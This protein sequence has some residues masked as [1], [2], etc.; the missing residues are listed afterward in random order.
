MAMRMLRRE[1]SP[2]AV[3]SA[4][5]K[6]E[7]LSR[8]QAY[9]YLLQGQSQRQLEPLPQAKAVF[10]VNLPRRLIQEVRSRC[11]GQGR[12]ISHVVAEV[13]QKW[14]DQQRTHG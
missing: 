12:P 14:L 2:G 11:R 6:A 1:Q 4:L 13:L 10:T 3:L 8:R 9:R 7:G 5:M